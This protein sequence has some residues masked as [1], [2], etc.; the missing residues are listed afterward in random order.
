MN[1][2][3]PGGLRRIH[4]IFKTHLDVGFTDFAADV[5]QNYFSSYIPKAIDLA[6]DLREMRS[7]DRFIWT[8]GSWLIYEYLEQAS[9]KQRKR[10]EEAIA[11]GDIAWHALPFTMHSENMD[12]PLFRFGLS[13]SQQLDQ[14]YGKKTIAAKMTDVPG[15]TRGILPLLAEAGVEFLHIGVNGASTPPDVPPVFTWRDHEGAEVVVMYHKD[16]YGDLM[17]IPV[18]PEAIAFALTGDNLGPQTAEALHLAYDRIRER[19]PRCEV[20]ASTMDAFAAQLLK[21]KDSLPVVTSEIGDTWIH[22]VGTDPKKEAQFRE[23]L[24]LRRE[25]TGH[26]AAAEGL[27]GFSRKLL[28]VPEHTWGL[29]VKTHLGD[30]EHYSAGQFRAAR[31]RENF[32]KM[33]RSW[34]EQRGYLR[35]AVDA[36]PGSLK[37][38][39]QAR[40]AALE[41][42]RPDAGNFKPIADL[43]RPFPLGRFN[44][45]VDIQ[46]G[47][48]AGLELDGVTLADPVHPLGK[49][50]VE[51]FSAADYQRFH[52]QYNVNKR[53][54]WFWAIPDF[55]KPGIEEAAKEHKL[56]FPHLAWAGKKSTQQTDTVLLL[57]DMPAESRQEYG[58]PKVIW[59][60]I[61]AGRETAELQFRL[62]WF[63]KPA[64]RLPEALWFSFRPRVSS[65]HGWALEKLGQWINPQDVIRDGNRRLHAVGDC[66]ARYTAGGQ[67]IS[68]S[69]PD[70]ALIAPGEPSLLDFHNRQPNLTKGIHFNLYNNL[71][72][73]N[74]PMWYEEDALFRFTLKIN[75]T[76]A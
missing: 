34:Q 21:I 31:E 9:S 45:V 65:P 41:P 15:H 49:F 33:E 13:L 76:K 40:L 43:T 63:E 27:A 75:T 60:E 26:G 71:W 57:L 37:D 25:W 61:Q 14:R 28:M 56:F 67:V 48:L 3:A 11:S 12:A 39:A 5:V 29:D 69:S 16:S 44:A 42:S 4:L 64:C 51:T 50:W 10:M 22:G 17:I 68:I 18:C 59:V 46:S 35:D 7:A 1:K 20:Q 23:L 70:A 8:T 6:R 24:R 36:L 54:T 2:D 52:R 72:G 53:E 62:Q 66:G 38:E 73:T 30:W 19:F 74:F 47:W 55:T 32:K 58:A